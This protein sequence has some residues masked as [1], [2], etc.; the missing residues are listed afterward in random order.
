MNLWEHDIKIG[1]RLGRGSFAQ[2][3]QGLWNDTA[4]AIKVIEYKEGARDAVDPCME[5]SLTKCGLTIMPMHASRI[6]RLR[7]YY[8]HAQ[9][10]MMAE[11]ACRELTHPN[12]VITYDYGWTSHEVNSLLSVRP[13]SV[14]MVILMEYCNLKSLAT[15]IRHTNRFG[16][17]AGSIKWPPI[18][19]A[20]I[21]ILRGL[22]YLHDMDIIHGDI[23][24]ANVMLKSVHKTVSPVKFTAKLADLGLAQL[25]G[26][27]VS[28]TPPHMHA[29]M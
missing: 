21:D 16:H 1:K 2:V 29:C 24:A 14:V 18:A 13:E 23:K 9:P 25:R 17:Q 4:V 6:H 7:R 10:G 12:V 15:N 22:T 26:D 5:A 3:F 28:P 8:I 11:S 19:H 20:L 27:A